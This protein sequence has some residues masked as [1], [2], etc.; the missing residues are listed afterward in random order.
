MVIRDLDSRISPS[1]I[2]T[3]NPDRSV[4]DQGFPDGVVLVIVGHWLGLGESQNMN[5]IDRIISKV[6]KFECKQT[7]LL[8]INCLMQADWLQLIGSR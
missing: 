5:Y 4:D 8:D 7:Q 3:K 1:S 6:L 2:W